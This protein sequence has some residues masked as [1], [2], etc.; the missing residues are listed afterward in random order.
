MMSLMNALRAISSFPPLFDEF[1]WKR[2][3]LLS[4]G[5]RDGFRV[6]DFHGR[7]DKYENTL[8][9]ILDTEESGHYL[10]SDSECPLGVS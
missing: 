5:G 10:V 8:M 4:R 7:C 6:E 9:L 2:F 3:V 1:R